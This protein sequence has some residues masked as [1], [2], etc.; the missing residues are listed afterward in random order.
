MTRNYR[1]TDEVIAATVLH[2]GPDVV[3]VSI[4][5]ADSSLRLT[6]SGRQLILTGDR[7]RYRTITARSKDRVF[8]WIDGRIHE[9]LEVEETGSAGGHGGS[10]DDIRAPMPGT[11]IKLNVKAGDSVAADQI[12]AVLEAMKMEHNLRAPRAGVVKVVDALVGQTVVADAPLVHL[13]SQ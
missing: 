5:C 6:K 12:V 10:L 9:L 13:E 11:V 8:V 7:Q 2:R 1:L 4:E 3:D